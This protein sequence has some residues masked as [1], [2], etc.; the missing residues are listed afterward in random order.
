MFASSNPNTDAVSMAFSVWQEVGMGANLGSIEGLSSLGTDSIPVKEGVDR[1]L[2]LFKQDPGDRQVIVTGRLGGIDTWRPEFPALPK[3]ARFLEDVRF[4]QPGVELVARTHLQLD[5]DQF[6][7]DHRYKG[8]YLFPTVFGLEAMAQSVAYVLR[9]G[10]L[11]A[12]SI[13]NVRLQKPLLVD[14]TRGL[15]IE[16]DARVVEDDTAFTTV[17][18]GIRSE[19]TGFVSDHFTA[20][21]VLGTRLD[22]EHGAAAAQIGSGTNIE[23]KTDLYGPILF[24]GPRFQ[25]ITSV[26]ALDSDRCVFQANESPESTFVLGDP[27]LRD[28]LLQSLQLC[29]LPDQCLPV[30][31]HRIDIADPNRATN[32]E[33]LCTAEIHDRTED[34]YVGSVICE[35]PDGETLER[36]MG[37]HAKIIERKPQWPTP[38][39]LVEGVVTTDDSSVSSVDHDAW[40]GGMHYRDVP[41]YGPQGQVAFFYRFPLTAQDLTG[42]YG[43]LGFANLYRWAGKVRELSG[44]NTPGGYS[45]LMKMLASQDLTAATNYFET[46]VLGSPKPYDL[47]EARYWADG[48]TRSD[49]STSYEWWRIPFP[50]GPRRPE[51]VARSRMKIS[52]VKVFEHGQVVATQWPDFFFQFLNGMGPQNHAPTPEPDDSYDLGKTIFSADEKSGREPVLEETIQTGFEDANVVGNIYFANYGA[53]QARARDRLLHAVA[54][55]LLRD[56]KPAVF[57]HCLGTGTFHVREAVPFDKVLVQTFVT[58]IRERGIRLEFTYSRIDG[59]GSLAKLAT[60][61]HEAA[62]VGQTDGDTLHVADWPSDA[63]ARLLDLIGAGILPEKAAGWP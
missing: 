34:A 14:P 27:Y 36:L 5:R 39:D 25:R 52:A 16:V 22:L 8:S 59:D 13:Q 40:E 23:P 2:E 46:R 61:Y 10:E 9:R 11:P 43:T 26:R 56:P 24:Q 1:F 7:G 33:R 32:G 17:D 31:I 45:E 60:G 35:G 37:Y 30:Q 63:K 57:L 49:V 44:I 41:G 51:L 28:A 19:Q 21:F 48:V 20:R 62:W 58:R 42:P 50:P 47:I 29:A 18:V 55:D 6:L 4:F 12:L 15:T 54:P 38:E 53:W 3:G